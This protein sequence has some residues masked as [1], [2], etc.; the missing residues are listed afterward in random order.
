[1]WCIG[2][3]LDVFLGTCRWQA[4]EFFGSE[5]DQ[6]HTTASDM[7][8]FACSCYEVKDLYWLSIGL[9]TALYLQQIFSGNVPFYEIRP[10]FQVIHTVIKGERP[11]RPPDDICHSRGLDDHMWGLMHSCWKMEP[12]ERL[13]ASEIVNHLQSRSTSSVEERPHHNWDTAFLSRHRSSLDICLFPSV[14]YMEAVLFHRN[15][16]GLRNVHEF[17]F[18][19]DSWKFQ[20][21][22]LITLQTNQ[23]RKW[24]KGPREHLQGHH[25]CGIRGLVET[26]PTSQIWTRI[27][28]DPSSSLTN[29][30]KP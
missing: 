2:W 25:H 7:Y 28:T 4:P 23:C 16:Q 10:D 1:M 24:R 12:A 5:I 17:G 3:F 14:A 21:L 18:P 13:T 29:R 8:S 15:A 22:I 9:T 6:G 26:N 20:R 19:K 30:V 27:G 11:S